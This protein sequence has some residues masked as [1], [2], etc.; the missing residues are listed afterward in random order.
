MASP[1]GESGNMEIDT[2]P[3]TITNPLFHQQGSQTTNQTPPPAQATNRNPVSFRAI[4]AEQSAVKENVQPLTHLDPRPEIYETDDDEADPQDDPLCPTI[5]ITKAEKCELRR[6][7]AHSLLVNLFE[8]GPGYI[9]I[10][11][12]LDLMWSLKG[13]MNLVDIGNAHYVARFSNADDY[14]H[15]LTEGPWMIGDNYLVIRRWV[16]NFDPFSEKEKVLTAWVRIPGLILEYFH[17]G[18]LKRIGGFIGKVIKVDSTTLKADRGQFVRL[19]VEVDLEKPILSKFKFLGRT[20]PIQYEGIRMLCYHCAKIGHNQEH[21]PSKPEKLTEEENLSR[22]VL[23]PAEVPDGVGVWNKVTKGRRKMITGNVQPNPQ[24]GRI[25]LPTGENT[26]E[27]GTESR[28]AALEVEDTCAQGGEMVANPVAQNSAEDLHTIQT[29]QDS[30]GPSSNLENRQITVSLEPVQNLQHEGN[31]K[32][33]LSKNQKK[34]EK[35]D[36]RNQSLSLN[37]SAGKFAI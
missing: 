34:K 12:R 14:N 28:F 17:G 3:T 13:T 18:F 6:P 23:H 11:R 2:I 10:R 20:W 29:A 32:D 1:A 22:V 16:P 31:S 25:I 8:K 30:M 35:R 37:K 4:V 33:F 36:I 24:A 7:W 27:V 15:V 21:C 19:A 5:R 26:E 9:Q